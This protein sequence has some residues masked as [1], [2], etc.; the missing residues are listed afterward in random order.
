MLTCA[1][2]IDGVAHLRWLD[3]IPAVGHPLAKPGQAPGIPAS[4]A[5][6]RRRGGGGA[7]I[8]NRRVWSGGASKGEPCRGRERPVRP[9]TRC[10]SRSSSSH[11]A[12]P[13]TEPSYGWAVPGTPDAATSSCSGRPRPVCT[14][15][16]RRPGRRR[17]R[18][19]CTSRTSSGAC[20]RAGST[21][22]ELLG[23]AAEGVDQGQSHQFTC[24]VFSTENLFSREHW[25]GTRSEHPISVPSGRQ[26]AAF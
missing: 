23:D 18:P 25:W 16:R 20:P 4:N 1:R 7:C 21:D 5:A 8:T 2:H 19:V 12:D 10:R 11:L 26:H 6:V 3:R 15:R 17:R 24:I 13:A 9:A 14:R 22:D